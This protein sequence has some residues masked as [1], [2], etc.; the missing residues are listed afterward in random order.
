MKMQFPMT[1]FGCFGLFLLSLS[2][3]KDP[4]STQSS[5]KAIMAFSL[6]NP[7]VTG[8]IDEE[9]K[10]VSLL[11]PEGTNVKSL[12]AVFTSNGISVAVGSETQTSG[13]TVND[14]SS[15]V[16]Y[17]VTA[18]D[19]SIATYT[20]TVSVAYKRITRFSF[21]SISATGS[22]DEAEKTVTVAV[23][24][25]TD[26]TSLV[27]EFEIT[28]AGV[29]VGAAVQES[30][31]TANDFSG[32][33]VYTVTGEDNSTADYTVTVVQSVPAEWTTYDWTE[34]VEPPTGWLNR[35]DMNSLCSIDDGI[36]SFSSADDA[37]LQ[38]HYRYQFSTTFEVGWKM[39][40]VFKARA[41]GDA[42][43]LGWMLDFQDTYRAQLEIRNGEASLQN[44][45]STISSKEI[46]AG[47]HTY[48]VSYEIME[49]GLRVNVHIDGEPTAALAGTATAAAG[50]IYLRLG[51]MSG[52]NTY[53][54]SLDWMLWTTDD[55]FFPG[56]VDM[57]EG[58]SLTP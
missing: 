35:E 6:V 36:L 50:S 34:T 31:V 5:E 44:G 51:D 54:G 7:S 41:D 30:G 23:P 48:F 39:T 27:A 2:C 20:V 52:N 28:G 26:V 47:W 22:I 53:Q 37:S 40:L 55:A 19:K 58:F 24:G 33:V 42:G 14:F 56:G 57:P 17:T 16:E 15:P 49:S 11:V 10:T 45:T 21:P 12:A 9:A 13:L 29:S 1:V 25:G 18:E 38:A 46:S 8:T 32:A 3:E 43:S 4:V